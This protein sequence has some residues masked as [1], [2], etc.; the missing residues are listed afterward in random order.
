MQRVRS[1]H[2]RPLRAYAGL[3]RVHRFQLRPTGMQRVRRFQLRPSRAGYL[4]LRVV[5]EEV[6]QASKFQR[7][8][9][10]LL[11]ALCRLW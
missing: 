2:N 7:A 1:C 6:W 5:I 4:A 9:C 3:Q 11:P 8:P 10:Q